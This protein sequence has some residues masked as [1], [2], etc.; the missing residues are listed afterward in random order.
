MAR[1]NK[2]EEA[3]EFIQGKQTFIFLVQPCYGD[4]SKCIFKV[5][6][7]ADKLIDAEN[8]MTQTYPLHN[9]SLEVAI[10]RQAIV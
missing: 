2:I 8:Y 9:S 3:K 1:K 10:R 4:T 7:I 6:V 5:S